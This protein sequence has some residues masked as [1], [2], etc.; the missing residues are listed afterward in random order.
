VFQDD[1]ILEAYKIIAK[2]MGLGKLDDIFLANFTTQRVL[3]FVEEY[4]ANILAVRFI[5]FFLL[6]PRQWSSHDL[7]DR[8]IGAQQAQDTSAST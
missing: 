8:M 6:S 2:D 5:P 4:G 3:G 7:P 1:S